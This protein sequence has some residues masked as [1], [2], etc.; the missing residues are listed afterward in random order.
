MS[1]LDEAREGMRERSPKIIRAL[2]RLGGVHVSEVSG[3]KFKTAQGTAFTLC[4]GKL[5]GD[6]RGNGGTIHYNIP[7]LDV[8]REYLAQANK[9]DVETV[10][11]LACER[12]DELAA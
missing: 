5:V 11:K 10:R 12:L 7:A 8:I 4:D 2:D 1:G 3:R 6:T 9:Q